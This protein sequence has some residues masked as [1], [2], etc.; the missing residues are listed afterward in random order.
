M[1]SETITPN[2]NH[3]YGPCDNL[4]TNQAEDLGIHLAL[5]FS[6]LH[7]RAVSTINSLH[8]EKCKAR[9]LSYLDL[10]FFCN[11]QQQPGGKLLCSFQSSF[12]RSIEKKG[13]KSSG[14]IACMSYSL[15]HG[16]LKIQDVNFFSSISSYCFV[17]EVVEVRLV[18]V[19]RRKPAAGKESQGNLTQTSKR[20]TCRICSAS[21]QQR[22][23]LVPAK[24]EIRA[25]TS[26]D[27]HPSPRS[28][29]WTTQG[30]S[31]DRNSLT[32]KN[33][34]NL[35]CSKL[36]NWDAVN[37]ED[38]SSP[39]NFITSRNLNDEEAADSKR[40]HPHP[41]LTRAV[42]QSSEIGSPTWR[43]PGRY[44]TPADLLDGQDDRSTDANS[45]EHSRNLRQ[46]FDPS[47]IHSWTSCSIR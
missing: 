35:T 14:R 27:H 45:I 8:T 3:S 10:Q 36:G 44:S 30:S 16:V 17:E 1:P 26:D 20:E 40:I 11:M 32:G 23:E 34:E 31:S 4:Q 42:L 24:P 19:K 39:S 46:P 47:G 21:A 18:V 22:R 12:R 29:L 7:F 15:P 41:F 33:A 25:T 28:E 37:S 2:Q 13:S 43:K 5:P 6:D 9:D 38:G